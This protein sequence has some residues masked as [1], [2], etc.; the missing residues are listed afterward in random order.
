LPTRCAEARCLWQGVGSGAVGTGS[1]LAGLTGFGGIVPFAS[2]DGRVR[3]LAR[4]R[5][6]DWDMGCWAAD[7]RSASCMLQG[8]RF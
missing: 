7:A 1:G 8:D 6:S 5:A 4:G 3:I 2:I